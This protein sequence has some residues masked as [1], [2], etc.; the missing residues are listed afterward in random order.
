MR[1]FFIFTLLSF[2]SFAPIARGMD[3]FTE[4]DLWGT[5]STSN[6]NTPQEMTSPVR[7]DD[8]GFVF[9]DSVPLRE[10][11]ELY[12]PSVER[13][14]AISRVIKNGQQGRSGINAIALSI[15]A[16]HYQA[17]F[18]YDKNFESLEQFP[19]DFIT[20]IHPY[21][22]NIDVLAR[23]LYSLS[24]YFKASS[25]ASYHSLCISAIRSPN[26]GVSPRLAILGTF[27]S[28]VGDNRLRQ[29]VTDPV[30]SSQATDEEI[31]E[32]LSLMIPLLVRMPLMD[33]DDSFI[34]LPEDFPVQIL[35]ENTRRWE[36]THF[37]KKV[38]KNE[39]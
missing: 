5:A 18:P 22:A 33:G 28:R 24:R 1:H 26:K 31:E 10:P 32:R 27:F 39:E 21:H 23:P 29:L 14:K 4:N 2:A 25:L 19:H 6:P 34:D 8:E 36:A 11:P 37:L 7:S 13:R 9:V 30:L 12:E 16:R 3:E 17:F 38:F 15:I 20:S 35:G